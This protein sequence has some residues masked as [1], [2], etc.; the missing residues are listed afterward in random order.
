MSVRWGIVGGGDL[1]QR[2][3]V[4]AFALCDGAELVAVTNRHA[5][6]AQAFAAKNGIASAFDSLDAMLRDPALDAVYI[7]TPNNLHAEHAIAA[8]EAGK[9]VLCDKPMALTVADCERMIDACAWHDVRLGVVFQNRYHPAHIEAR[10]RIAGGVLGEI[11]YGSARLCIGRPRGHWQ[12]W[13]LDPGAA[14]SGAI[15]GQALHPIDLLR[16]LMDSE[17]VDVQCMA[18]QAPPERPVDELCFALLRFANGAHATVVAGTAAPRVING[19]TLFGSAAR[20]ACSGTIGPP[21]SAVSQ[22]LA[23]DGDDVAHHE[24]YDANTSPQRFAAMFADFD[25]CIAAKREP[26]IS[27]RNG[28][29]MVRIANA[30]QESSEHGRRVRI[31]PA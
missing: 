4:P 27:G 8:A 30:L 25:E 9:H 29:Q 13:R 12:G 5:D 1:A 18:D 19:A 10:R 28:L 24:A 23:I 2:N 16:F 6:R 11:Q 21:S 17:V 14:G 7:A 3:L 15:V 22:A 31:V 26:S 20:V